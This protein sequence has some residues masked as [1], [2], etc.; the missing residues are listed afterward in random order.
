MPC[1]PLGKR[2]KQVKFMISTKILFSSIWIIIF[3]NI[4]NSAQFIYQIIISRQLALAEFSLFSSLMAYYS[5]LSLPFIIFPYLLVKFKNT[6]KKDLDHLKNCLVFFCL[7]MIFIQSILILTGDIFLFKI[8]KNDNLENYIIIMLWYLSTFI[9]LIPANLKLANNKY[10]NYTAY[11]NLPLIIK[12]II[13]ILVVFFFKKLTILSVLLINF[14]SVFILIINIKTIKLF[15]LGSL[16]NSFLFFKK[17]LFFIFGVCVTLFFVNFLQNIDIISLRYLFTEQQS[18]YL[19]GAIFIGKIPFYFLSILIITMFPEIYKEKN[20]IF[21]NFKMLLMNCFYLY[22]FIFFMYILSSVVLTKFDF[23]VFALGDKF[24]NSKEFTPISMLYY[25]QLFIFCLV[26]NILIQ[27]N[28]FK[29]NIFILLI[30]SAFMFYIFS[31]SL[32]PFNYFLIKNFLILILNITLLI[33]LFRVS[34]L[35]PK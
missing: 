25:C 28:Q 17:N 15:I 11:I 22:V 12:L 20:E 2:I 24:F 19:A 4:G 8:L 3:S 30:I 6:N 35:S 23:V 27:K 34:N 13:V 33:F 31:Q 5:I 26:S 29:Y 16:S 32:I 21:L 10:K 1:E 9:F 14:F 7:F 18:G